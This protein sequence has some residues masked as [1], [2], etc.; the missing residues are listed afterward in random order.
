MIGLSQIFDIKPM[1]TN[2]PYQRLQAMKIF[3]GAGFPV[4]TSLNRRQGSSNR[5]RHLHTIVSV[6][7]E[8]TALKTDGLLVLYDVKPVGLLHSSHA[9]VESFKVFH[10]AT[11][12]GLH[13]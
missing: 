9:P 8:R 5:C 7:G 10:I 13:H 6:Y 1:G 11:A 12:Y 2:P 4:F 3:Q